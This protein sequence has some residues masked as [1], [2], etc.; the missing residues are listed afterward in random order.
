MVF[1]GG[2]PGEYIEI[3]GPGVFGLGAQKNRG[4]GCCAGG[5]RAIRGLIG[6]GFVSKKPR[7]MQWIC[8]PMESNAK[9][10][11]NEKHLMWFF[12]AVFDFFSR[13]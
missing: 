4:R 3:G 7:L 13:L 1:G 2:K 9:R 11:S 6:F 5:R 10:P 8:H 12:F